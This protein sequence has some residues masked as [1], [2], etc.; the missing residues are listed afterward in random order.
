MYTGLYSISAFGQN[1][2]NIN[3]GCLFLWNDL[4]KYERPNDVNFIINLTY[5]ENVIVDFTTYL[6]VVQKNTYTG[7]LSTISKSISD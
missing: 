6:I 5:G 3:K 4:S 1:E 2:S 7:F